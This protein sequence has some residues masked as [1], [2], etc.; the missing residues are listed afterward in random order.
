VLLAGLVVLSSIVARAVGVQVVE[1]AG[2]TLLIF[3]SYWAPAGSD[4]ARTTAF[5]LLLLLT[6]IPAAGFLVEPLMAVTAGIASACLTLFGIPALR[7]GQFF[8][9]PGSSFEV[10]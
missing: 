5:P 3:T 8:A 10:A 1:F 6:A 2:A 4:A 9:L 7:D